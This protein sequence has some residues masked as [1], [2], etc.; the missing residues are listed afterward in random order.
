MSVNKKNNCWF[1]SYFF[2]GGV[3][4]IR[5]AESEFCRL[6]PYHLATTPYKHAP[7]LIENP[8]DF[9]LRLHTESVTRQSLEQLQQDGAG[10]GNRTREST[11]ARLHFTTKLYLHQ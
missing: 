3:G 9:L 5:T 8:S 1:D 11:L 7:T 2:Y 10:S 4:R 6:V